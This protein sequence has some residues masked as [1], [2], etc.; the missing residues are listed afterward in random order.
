M[1]RTLSKYG[2]VSIS[3]DR[4]MAG[5][6]AYLLVNKPNASFPF[7]SMSRRLVGGSVNLVQQSS[8][9]TSAVCHWSVDL[10]PPVIFYSPVS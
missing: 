7:T 8:A 1:E 3:L 9:N 5:A 6:A 2:M 4:E 10:R